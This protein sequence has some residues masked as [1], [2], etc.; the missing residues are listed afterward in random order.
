M[1]EE[2]SGSG[3]RGWVSIPAWPVTNVILG[4]VFLSVKTL[5]ALGLHGNGGMEVKCMVSVTECFFF[6]IN[7]A[8]L[9][10]VLWRVSE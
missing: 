5:P 2:G 7:E 9:Y 1:W 3:V 4:K 8:V 10:W 6:Q